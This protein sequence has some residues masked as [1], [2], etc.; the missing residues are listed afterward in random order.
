MAR[1]LQSG[2][3]PP[4]KVSPSKLNTMNAELEK[5]LAELVSAAKQTGTDVASF[6]AQQAPDVL[7]QIIAWERFRHGAG[8][9]CS[10]V[11]LA[12]GLYLL[13]KAFRGDSVDSEPL[14]IAGA[15]FAAPSAVIACA[16]TAGLVKTYIAPK[17]IV[18][19]YIARHL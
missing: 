17:L 14:F 11:F 1:L 19:D 8:L 18:L 7:Q 9:A 4:S 13:S 16:T 3:P 2:A 10:L 12:L 15:V 6:I 5:Q